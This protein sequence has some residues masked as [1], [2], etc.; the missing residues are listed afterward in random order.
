MAAGALISVVCSNHNKNKMCV[1]FVFSSER[2]NESEEV[3]GERKDRAQDEE[4]AE[5]ENEENSERNEFTLVYF[6]RLS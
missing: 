1:R 4:E 2:T 5:E 6:I 3:T